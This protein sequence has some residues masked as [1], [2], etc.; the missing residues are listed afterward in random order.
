MEREKKSVT[1]DIMKPLPKKI[2]K[3]Q[4]VRFRVAVLKMRRKPN[5]RA[6][7]H[8]VIVLIH[9]GGS[10]SLS[11]EKDPDKEYQYF[12]PGANGSGWL[13]IKSYDNANLA[14]STIISWDIECLPVVKPELEVLIDYLT[15][16]GRHVYN[17]T[18]GQ[19]CRYWV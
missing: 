19:G 10:V 4:M 5:D 3:S 6:K 7:N 9:R 13:A 16:T 2:L 17:M 8:W 18:E 11:M 1:Y 15:Q 12:Y 14:P